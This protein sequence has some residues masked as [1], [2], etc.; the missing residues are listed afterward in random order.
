MGRSYYEDFARYG[1]KGSSRRY[2]PPENPLKKEVQGGP[3]KIGSSLRERAGGL[4]IKSNAMTIAEGRTTLRNG[5]M[6][7]A[8]KGVVKL[9]VP[10]N[11]QR[12]VNRP[13][14]KRLLPQPL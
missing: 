13:Y 8:N 2:L 10:K 1:S 7:K 3:K 12:L 9:R 14:L 5:N 6:K 4:M 11:V